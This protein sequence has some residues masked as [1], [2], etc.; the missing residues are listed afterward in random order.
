MK[1]FLITL[2][3]G[4]MAL[5]N[6]ANAAGS[7]QKISKD[8]IETAA[9]AANKARHYEGSEAYGARVLHDEIFGAA[10]LVG[11]SDEVDPSTYVVL[12][13][14]T[15]DRCRIKGVVLT[16]EAD[17]IEFTPDEQLN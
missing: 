17:S 13:D 11:I 16:N 12:V 14:K 5:S 10:I 7:F 1:K 6:L 9:A 2:A 4:G 3:V 8:C 15:D